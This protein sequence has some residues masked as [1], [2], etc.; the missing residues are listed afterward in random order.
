MLVMAG[1]FKPVCKAKLSADYFDL[2]GSLV[3]NSAFHEV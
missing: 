1:S 2:N 3:R